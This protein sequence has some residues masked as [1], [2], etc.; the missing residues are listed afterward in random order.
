M[1]RTVAS[2]TRVVLDVPPRLK[3]APAHEL[4]SELSQQYEEAMR[5]HDDRID[6]LQRQ[7]L[8]CPGNRER[9]SAGFNDDRLPVHPALEGLVDPG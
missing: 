5:P 2:L 1:I 6:D 3:K 8:L 9:Y 7:T 4:G